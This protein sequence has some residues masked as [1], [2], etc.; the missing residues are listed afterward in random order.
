M[1]AYCWEHAKNIFSV[2]DLGCLDVPFASVTMEHVV[3]G[4]ATLVDPKVYK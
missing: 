1:T 3:D 2:S 4:A